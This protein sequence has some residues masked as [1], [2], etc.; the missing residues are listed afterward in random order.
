MQNRPIHCV[1]MIPQLQCDACPAE[2]ANPLFA[3]GWAHPAGY[4]YLFNLLECCTLQGHILVIDLGVTVGVTG[5][6]PALAM[7]TADEM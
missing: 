7:A 2:Q 6:V 3:M 5:E 4:V 1:T